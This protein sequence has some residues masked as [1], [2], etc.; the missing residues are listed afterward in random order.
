MS[1]PD[2]TFVLWCDISLYCSCFL[3]SKI[4]EAIAIVQQHSDTLRQVEIKYDDDEVCGGSDNGVML[5][6][7]VNFPS[8]G[9]HLLFE[10]ITQLLRA[11]EVYDVTR[12]QLRYAMSLIGGTTSSASF[13]NLYERFGPT[14]AGE[15]DKEKGTYALGYPGLLFHFPIPQKY[16]DD[17]IAKPAEL[18]LEFPDGTT[19]VA[20]RVCVF[21]NSLDDGKSENIAGQH[22]NKSVGLLKAMVNASLPSKALKY[23]EQVRVMLGDGGGLMFSNGARIDFGDSPQDVWTQ[24]GS[25]GDTFSKPSGTMLLHSD[26]LGDLDKNSKSPDYFYNYFMRGIDVLFDGKTHCAKKFILHTNQV[27]HPE[28]NVYMKCNFAVEVPY[29]VDE[30]RPGTDVNATNHDVSASLSMENGVTGL[31]E[32]I[33]NSGAAL[34]SSDDILFHDNEMDLYE[35]NSGNESLQRNL[36]GLIT[37]ESTFDDI[38]KLLGDGGRATIHTQFMSGSSSNPFGSTLIYGFPQRITFEIMKSGRIANLTIF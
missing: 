4:C 21:G 28:F 6:I 33:S 38:Q 30:R 25:P 37:T 5:D 8:Y 26:V 9:F 23:F 18:P 24:L 19:P 35:E 7:V 31:F 27:G 14:Y 10:P 13:V 29:D 32:E 2:E 22:N 1:L 20:S 3:N 16:A 15:Y 17:C 12:I 36:K 11:V 34:E